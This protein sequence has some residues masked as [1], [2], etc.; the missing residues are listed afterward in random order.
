MR[1]K[2]LVAIIAVA[3][4]IVFV[5]TAIVGNQLAGKALQDQSWNVYRATRS[6][7]MTAIAEIGEARATAVQEMRDEEGRYKPW[8]YTPKSNKDRALATAVHELDE[9]IAMPTA[10]PVPVVRKEKDGTKIVLY[11]GVTMMGTVIVTATFITY[12]LVR[13]LHSGTILNELETAE[14]VLYLQAETDTK[15]RK[16]PYDRNL[17]GF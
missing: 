14:R 8:M 1:D 5:A 4:C 2:S 10:T 6:V 11:V 9:V 17:E 7:H 15:T 12:F 13:Y 16:L 3:V